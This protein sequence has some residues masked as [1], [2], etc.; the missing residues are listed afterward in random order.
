MTRLDP[1]GQVE[2]FAVGSSGL[3]GSAHG[4]M[5]STG[6]FIVFRYLFGQQL[7]E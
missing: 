3:G 5:T 4:F 1:S 6:T 2:V 7:I